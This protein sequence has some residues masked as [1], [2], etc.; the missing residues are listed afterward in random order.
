MEKPKFSQNF[1]KKI[2]TDLFVNLPQTKNYLV[3]NRVDFILN[4]F[5]KLINLNKNIIFIDCNYNYNYLPIE[6]K[7]LFSRSSVNLIKT[8]KYFNVAAVVFFNLSNKNYI[9]RKILN[10]NCINIS[11]SSIHISDKLDINLNSGNSDILNYLFYVKFIQIYT[12]LKNN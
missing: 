9:F 11:F 5:I 8:F 3:C 12:S 4:F 2:P 7:M 10:L 6:N 1:F